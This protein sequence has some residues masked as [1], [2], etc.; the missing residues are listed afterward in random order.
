[1]MTRTSRE[2]GMRLGLVTP[3]VNLNP[4]FDPPAWEIEGGIDELVTIARTAD[5]LGYDW[6]GCPEHVAIPSSVAAIRGA[7]YWDPVV[8]LSYLAACTQRIG[9]LSHVT[10]LGYHHP[11]AI[12]K[13][14]GTLDVASGGRVILGVG[15]GS[16]QS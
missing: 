12:V 8:T 9:L 11:L 6:L 5:R 10:V 14:Y 16:L 4:R 13:R 1:M 3:I 2:V 15:V 7:R